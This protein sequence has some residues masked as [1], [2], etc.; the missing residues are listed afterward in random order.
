MSRS[1]FRPSFR[2]LLL[3][4]ILLVAG[5][6]AA[7]ALSSLFALERL[8]A[9]SRSAADRA[10]QLS[11][12][13]QRQS[14][15]GVAMERAAR[16]YLVLG[17]PALLRNYEE[18]AQE[19]RRLFDARLAPQLARPLA[20]RWHADLASISAALGIGTGAAARPDDE[21]AARF[22]D[23]AATNAE[24]AAA[25]RLGREAQD[26]EL[27]ARLE[28][29]RVAMT[30]RV[31]GAIAL[32]LLVAAAFGLWLT[33]PLLGLER[34]IIGLGEN[35]LDAPVAIGGP[36]DL[37]SLGQRLEWLRLRL[38][39]LDAD[40]A[41]FLR[42]VSHELKTPLAALREGVALLED[43]VAGTLTPD[44][45]EV[46]TI[47][48]Q[49]TAALQRQIEALLGFN[50]A[51]FEARRLQR[52]RPDLRALLR[53]QVDGQ[54]LQWQARRLRVAVEG[55]ALEAEVDPD[56]LGTALANLLSNAIRYAPPGSSIEIA[57]GRADGGLRIDF[58]D[59][60]PGVA[61]ADRARVFEPFYRGERQP[62]GALRGSGIGLSIVREYVE[63]HG[64]RV[65][66]MP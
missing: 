25:V 8:L 54:R 51:A 7:A 42:H 50:A 48:A 19:A 56:K 16:Q 36:S 24:V 62:E 57:L 32:A 4:A 61:E 63:A 30:H 23:L 17:D 44:Q 18:S 43:G 11:Q 46:A 6:L 29:G 12:A 15:Q 52:R 39:E 33:R 2:Q 58:R 37:R 28:A 49:N 3:L 13:V 14:E 66:L 26:R 22:R 31:L 27:Q 47:L 53:A 40:K 38:G 9:Q 35:R 60:G 55:P 65:E 1:P 45:R 21:L 41:R 5:L 20:A 10:V 34:A 59:Q 64:G